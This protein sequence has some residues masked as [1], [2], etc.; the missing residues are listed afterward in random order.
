MF[1]LPHL[2]WGKNRESTQISK[3]I[4]IRQIIFLKSINIYIQGYKMKNET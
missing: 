2:L 1:R 4:D 3:H